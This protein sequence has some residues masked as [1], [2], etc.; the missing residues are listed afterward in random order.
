MTNCTVLFAKEIIQRFFLCGSLCI[1]CGS[2]CNCFYYT[3]FHGED[4]EFH[5]DIF[6]KISVIRVPLLNL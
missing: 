6:A 3:E 5:R 2:L 1:L 4:T